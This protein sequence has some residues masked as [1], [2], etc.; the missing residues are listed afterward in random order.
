[1]LQLAVEIDSI[2][3]YYIAVQNYYTRMMITSS[4]DLNCVQPL[5]NKPFKSHLSALRFSTIP[6]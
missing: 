4:R 1:M 2:M 3:I 6:L 5:F